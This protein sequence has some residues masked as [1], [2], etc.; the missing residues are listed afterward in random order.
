MRRKFRV[1]AVAAV[2]ASILFS[3]TCSA[4]WV[5]HQTTVTVNGDDSLSSIAERYVSANC[6]LAEYRE[7]IVEVN[8]DAVFGPRGSREVRPG[9]VLRIYYWVD[10]N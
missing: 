6:N 2:A 9:D 10:E 5:N 4:R 1:V 8:Y 7:G 3:G